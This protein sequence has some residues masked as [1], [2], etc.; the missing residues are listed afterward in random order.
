MV[1]IEHGWM[2]QR[3]LPLAPLCVVCLTSAPGAA[4]PLPGDGIKPQASLAEAIWTNYIARTNGRTMRLWAQYTCPAGWP[5]SAT[6]VLAWDSLSLVTAYSNYTGISQCWEGQVNRG[7]V[8]VTLL[9]RRHAYTR[10]HHMGAP[11]DGQAHF[12]PSRAGQRVWFVTP[13]NQVVEARIANWLTRL[14]RKTDENRNR[15]PNQGGNRNRNQNR[16][17]DGYFDYSLMVFSNDLP[18]EIT[19][20]KV[21]SRSDYLSL[22]TSDTNWPHVVLKT[23]QGGRVSSGVAPF[24]CDT[25]K[26]GDSGSPD[27][28]PIG[29]YLVFVGGRSTSG[30]TEQM[31]ADLDALTESLGLD[32]NKYQLDWV[33]LGAWKSE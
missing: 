28:L 24:I 31:Q 27:M 33:D 21:M 1:W 13:D 17:R 32:T 5:T 4:S 6:P 16:G 3:V 20:L 29:D 23:E 10:G 8:P 15:N 2:L 18:V 12:R 25:W 14:G 22:C 7:Q 11:P 9:T 26:G 19:P 30:P